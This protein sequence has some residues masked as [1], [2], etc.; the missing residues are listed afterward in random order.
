MSALQVARSRSHPYGYGRISSPSHAKFHSLVMQSRAPA[1]SQ[2]P[3]A[4]VHDCL[5]IGRSLP[6]SVRSVASMQNRLW[7]RAPLHAA[8][9]ARNAHAV[10][11][12]CDGCAKTLLR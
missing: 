3:L 9:F 11:A 6:T 7:T 2:T 8:G 1:P 10:Y 4:M 12:V 5:F